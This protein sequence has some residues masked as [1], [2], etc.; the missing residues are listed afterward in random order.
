MTTA[1]IYTRVSD[2]R[3]ESDGTSLLTQE[4]RCRAHAAAASYVVSE[5]HVYVEVHTGVELW[6][7]PQM[8][9]LRDAFK[10][11][12][13][14]VLVV[15]AIDRLARDPV[16]MGVIL[17]EAEHY[18]VRIEFVTEVLDSSPE[19]QLIRYVRGYSA[20]V[21]H[22]KIRERSMRGRLAVVRAGRMWGGAPLYGYATDH[23]IGKRV[24]VDT[25]ADVVRS[26]FAQYL[27][28]LSMRAIAQALNDQGVPAP[29][30][31]KRLYRDDR[32]PR[33]EPTTVRQ[34]LR[35]EAY[36][37]VTYAWR[38][39]DMPNGTKVKRPRQEWIRLPDGTTPAI[40]DSTQF[41]A[42]Q[43]QLERNRGERAR[44]QQRPALLRGL[45]SCTVCGARMYVRRHQGSGDLVYACKTRINDPTACTGQQARAWRVDAWA[46]EH[47][48]ALLMDDALIETEIQRRRSTQ[49]QVS[50]SGVR[51]L[52]RRMT[53]INRA[54]ERLM[55]RYST[56]ENF[57]WELVEREVQRLEGEKA[58]V[59]AAIAKAENIAHAQQEFDHHI[60]RFRNWREHVAANLDSM[61][62]DERRRT[63][64]L[65]GVR[66]TV[67]GSDWDISL[68]LVHL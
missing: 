64:E 19:G 21:E 54:Q 32:V 10:R 9:A 49:E 16:H 48:R 5:Q 1:A 59:R 58:D 39:K 50:D 65:L 3:Q 43:R 17:T 4:E 36:T 2:P 53:Q 45:A 52:R 37:G 56:S 30:A 63:L 18:G 47:V 46:W 7:R 22:E 41:E 20:K 57:P 34:I 8:T 66:V 61:T 14:E 25:E 12:E 40:I 44:N 6:E 15:Y 27:S 11:R 24:I 67:S 28:G 23:D 31:G 13:F 55:E 26:I 62:F 42:V 33:W 35:H 60:Q 29:T 68:S 51:S 38:W